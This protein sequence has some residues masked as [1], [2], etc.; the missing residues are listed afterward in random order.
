[1]LEGIV[2]QLMSSS[3]GSDI[4]SQL[5]Q[6]GLSPDKA[7]EA[8]QATAEGAEKHGGAAGFDL[9]GLMNGSQGNLG[10]V[11]GALGGMTGAGSSGAGA[12]SKLTEPVTQF[13][14]E[15]G[16]PEGVAQK[17]VSVV[18]PKL[19]ELVQKH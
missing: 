14:K 1:M 5:K 15:K 11:A 7:Q 18:L 3:Q 4:L 2:K 13:V 9:G 8:V 19:L 16:F 6:E 12:V 17:V 10:S